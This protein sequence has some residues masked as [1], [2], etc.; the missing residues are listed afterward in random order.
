MCVYIL[1]VLFP[2]HLPIYT[3][4]ERVR[5]KERFHQK[6]S[7]STLTYVFFFTD[8][9]YVNKLIKTFPQNEMQVSLIQY[10]RY[11]VGDRLEMVSG[12]F[13]LTQFDAF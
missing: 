9:S 13:V 8:L 4:R 3:E 5:E 6:E 12:N 2:S 7:I 10:T 1:K 11:N